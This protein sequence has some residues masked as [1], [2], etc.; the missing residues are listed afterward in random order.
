M[1]VKTARDF[2][3][4]GL[5]VLRFDFRGSGNSEGNFVDMTAPGEISDT[6]AALDFLSGQIEVD[7]ERM[8]L[9]GLSLG[10][11]VAACTVEHDTRVK[12]LVLWSAAAFSSAWREVKGVSVRDPIQW[13]LPEQ[14]SVLRR[15]GW[16]DIGGLRLGVQFLDRMQEVEPLAA[17]AKYK[18]PVLIV[19]GSEDEIVPVAD[20]HAYYGAASG[21]K[22]LLIVDGADHTYN[23]C[24]WEKRVIEAS[25]RWF[26]DTL[27][28]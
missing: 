27:A 1:F 11:C 28:R 12:S 7:K 25:R 4:N 17:I 3:Q 8:G 2:A 16:F 24:S 18:G 6:G 21:R 20:A 15:Q 14:E 10:G 5:A 19:H 9:L 26:V 23:T 13:L 22:E